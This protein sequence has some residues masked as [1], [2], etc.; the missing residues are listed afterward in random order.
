V[1]LAVNGESGPP[2]DPHGGG[3]QGSRG[4]AA[5]EAAEENATSS[6]GG[7]HE[8]SGEGRWQWMCF[9]DAT[10]TEVT[11]EQVLATA[12]GGEGSS[13]SAYMLM[14]ARSDCV[15]AVAV[16]PDA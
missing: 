9:N 11:E 7:M 14:Y 6:E 13:T 5:S 15:D 1:A 8:P 4:A 2:G 16:R 3:R 12:G 10:I